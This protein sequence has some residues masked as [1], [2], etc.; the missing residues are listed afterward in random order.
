[1][2]LPTRL[3]TRLDTR[4]KSRISSIIERYFARNSSTRYATI[5][6]ATVD[7]IV[8]DVNP[9]AGNGNT[10]LPAG[11]PAVTDNVLQTIDFAYTGTISELY[12]NGSDIFNGVVA[13]VEMYLGS[14]LV[15][16]YSVNG[17]V[18]RNDVAE[19]GAELV[20]NGNFS[21]GVA[22]WSAV[23]GWSIY[24][25]IAHAHDFTSAFQRLT[26]L[27]A[28]TDVGVTYII[29]VDCVEYTSGG[30]YLRKP[31]DESVS[32]TSFLINRV[33]TYEFVITVGSE[34][35]DVAFANLT[36]DTNLKISNVS[37]RRADGYGT[38]VNGNVEDI[39]LFQRKPNGDWQGKNLDVPP[40]D[41]VD[42]TM[43]KA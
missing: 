8:M 11:A 13:N 12:K 23:G 10:G 5:P 19:L 26:A 3:K 2:R 15:R 28:A 30:V 42:Q 25:G 32:D 22:G 18:L 1:M 21:D 40:W 35:T 31:R 34:N 39:G 9:D 29:T 7:R 36:V 27:S 4:L 6:T 41:S 43:V 24:G 33:G 16:K 17:R 20:A 37:V 14:S 38:V